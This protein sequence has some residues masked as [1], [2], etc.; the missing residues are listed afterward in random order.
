MSGLRGDR[1]GDLERV[2]MSVSACSGIQTLLC[3]HIAV[4]GGGGYRIQLGLVEFWV[5]GNS[6]VFHSYC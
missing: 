3:N 1:C 2:G 4:A 6:V 5:N